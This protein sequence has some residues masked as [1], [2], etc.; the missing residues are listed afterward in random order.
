[1]VRTE[2]HELKPNYHSKYNKVGHLQHVQVVVS[3]VGDQDDADVKE[4]RLRQIDHHTSDAVH[5]ALY[6]GA[7]Y[8]NCEG[9]V[10]RLFKVLLEDVLDTHDTNVTD[11]QDSL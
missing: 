8:T 4:D 1:M 5:A 7:P 2:R 11:V 10:C 9:L 6:N 3:A